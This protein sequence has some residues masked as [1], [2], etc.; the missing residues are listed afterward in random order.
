MVAQIE[1]L[2]TQAFWDRRHR[3]LGSLTSG[4]DR[5][6]TDLDNQ[7]FYFTRLDSS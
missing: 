6:L 5:G 4:G 3:E 7:A 1:P 2:E